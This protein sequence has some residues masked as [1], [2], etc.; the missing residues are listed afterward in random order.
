MEN[1][2]L[3]FV[4]ARV[5]R[6]G[7]LPATYLRKFVLAGRNGLQQLAFGPATAAHVF[8]RRAEAED[9]ARRLRRRASSTE[10][11]FRAEEAPA[12]IVGPV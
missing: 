11:D 7:E 4:V 9:V 5:H 3:R 2:N 1:G 8:E 6:R 10:Y 12:A